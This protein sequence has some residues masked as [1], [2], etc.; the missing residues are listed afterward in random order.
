MVE[1]QIGIFRWMYSLSEICMVIRTD[2]YFFLLSLGGCCQ[3]TPRFNVHVNQIFDNNSFDLELSAFFSKKENSHHCHIV[4]DVIA[5][6][7]L[8]PFPFLE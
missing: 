1:I 4:N 5:R 6:L 7:S 3:L 8:S 2:G